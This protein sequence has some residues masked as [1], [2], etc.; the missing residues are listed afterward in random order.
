[1]PQ[2]NHTVP[3]TLP[4]RLLGCLVAQVNQSVALNR[5]KHII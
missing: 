3:K 1:M 2:I 5:N 4:N